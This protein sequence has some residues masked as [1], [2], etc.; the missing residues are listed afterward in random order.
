MRTVA[1]HRLPENVSIVANSAQLP[2]R[3][4]NAR[5]FV[6]SATLRGV[7]SAKDV[8]HLHV[9]SAILKRNCLLNADGFA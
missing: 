5:L 6:R 3:V 9:D 2:G 4:S 1:L 8:W 7:V